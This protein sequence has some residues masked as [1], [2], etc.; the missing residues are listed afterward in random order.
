MDRLNVFISSRTKELHDECLFVKTAST[1]LLNDFVYVFISE[2]DSVG[3]T[4]SP[5]IV[6]SYKVRKCDIYIGPT[7]KEYRIAIE[8]EKVI[9][10]F[11]SSYD[12]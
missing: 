2:E 10:I 4:D 12:I 3:T 1:D 6:Y 7:E 8:N 11:V 9:L 5:E